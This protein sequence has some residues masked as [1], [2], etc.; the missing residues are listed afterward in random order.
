MRI[1]PDMAFL[2]RKIISLSRRPKFRFA[3][4]MMGGGRSRNHA[5]RNAQFVGFLE[6]SGFRTTNPLRQEKTMN[7]RRFV[8]NL[9]VG[10]LLLGFVWVMMES[11]HALSLF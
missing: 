5:V 3:R 7:R 4:L 9:L 8:V 1:I 2:I 11:A 10:F 6:T